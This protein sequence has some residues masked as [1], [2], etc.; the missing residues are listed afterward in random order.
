MS[1]NTFTVI[2]IDNSYALRV[3]KKYIEDVKLQ[4]GQK[5]TIGLPTPHKSGQDQAKSYYV[6]CKRVKSSKMPKI[7]WHGNVSYVKIDFY[8]VE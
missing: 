1:N 3:P 5:T 2:K 4:S 6:S 8:L 7:L